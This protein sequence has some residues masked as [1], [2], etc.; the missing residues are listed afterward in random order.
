MKKLIKKLL[1][2]RIGT[3]LLLEA[4]IIILYRRLDKATIPSERVA[5]ALLITNIENEIDGL[6]KGL[7][8]EP[9]LK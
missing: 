3:I 1:N 2:S 7:P 4:F 8:F 6:K 9:I 5:L